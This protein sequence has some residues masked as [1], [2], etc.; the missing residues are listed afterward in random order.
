MFTKESF[1]TEVERIA[2]KDKLSY[3][4]SMVE[5]CRMH[6]ID[7]RDIKNLIAAPMMVKLEAEARDRSV[8]IDD[9]ILKHAFTGCLQFDED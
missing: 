7:V 3:A 5:L 6:D 9:K 2:R 8:I 1:T 4:S